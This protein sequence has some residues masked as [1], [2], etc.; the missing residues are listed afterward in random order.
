MQQI[1]DASILS[2]RQVAVIGR[3]MEN[4]I[5]IGLQSGYI[6]APKD[7]FVKPEDINRIPPEK[8]TILSTGSQGEPLAALSRIAAG[9][10][11][12]IK[13]IP[14]D[15]VIFSSSPIPGNQEPINR[16]INALFRIGADVI[17][18]G[19][20]ADTHTSGHGNQFDLKL[21]LSLTKPKFFIPVHGEHR[22]LKFHR[23]LAI[24]VGV[25]PQNIL[26]MDNGDVAAVSKDTIRLAGRVQ[27]DDVYVDGTGIGD[28][29]NNIIRE[30]KMLS[31][32]GMFAVIITVDN[33]SRKIIGDPTIISRGFI[34]MKSNEALTDALANDTK[35]FV[36]NVFNNKNLIS[37][38]EFKTKL[39][40]YLTDKIYDITQRKPMIIPVIRN[41]NTTDL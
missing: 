25:D 7:I 36:T 39:S 10:H 27:A 3:S 29:S 16:T 41:F 13:A 32:D 38:S 24:S 18:H 2:N 17:T 14:G 40:D 5:E 34:Y 15:T 28:I 23:D 12:F 33:Q 37:E 20:L 6:K 26:I 11:R 31:D 30:R 22:M 35:E 21:L 8:L 4:A 1:I 19:P 9:S